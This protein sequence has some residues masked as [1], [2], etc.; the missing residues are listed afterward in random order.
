MGHAGTRD[1][2]VSIATLAAV[3]VAAGLTGRLVS[4]SAPPRPS[5]PPPALVRVAQVPG[6]ASNLPYGV[7]VSPMHT[8]WVSVNGRWKQ[9]AR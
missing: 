9:V 3:A 2:S 6:A 4:G 8:L 5:V 7:S 1:R